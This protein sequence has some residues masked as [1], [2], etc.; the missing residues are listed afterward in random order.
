MPARMSNQWQT[1]THHPP[2]SGATS[3]S[4]PPLSDAP[5]APRSVL[6][7]DARL[8]LPEFSLTHRE[9]CSSNRE[10]QILEPT[11][12]PLKY[13]LARVSN[14]ES[15]QI[16]QTTLN[17]RLNLNPGS[18]S[19]VP[20]ILPRLYS[21]HWRLE[22]HVTHSKQTI[23]PTSNRHGLGSLIGAFRTSNQSC[24]AG[25]RA[26][27]YHCSPPNPVCYSHRRTRVP[28]NGSRA[29]APA[30]PNPGASRLLRC[31]LRRQPAPSLAT[32]PSP[33]SPRRFLCVFSH[34]PKT[35]ASMK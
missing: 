2:R 10:T 33:N 18:A 28:P 7:H 26:S 32:R 13:C 4:Q 23:G 1:R 31:F 17:S 6:G 8:H 25:T 30:R 24:A 14:R 5:S 15:L 9:T 11:R 16:F 12:N 20:A 35:N 27:Q 21:T 29:T 3:A 19:R 34:Q 22:T